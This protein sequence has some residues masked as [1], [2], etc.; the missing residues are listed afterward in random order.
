MATLT[1][2]VTIDAP[3]EKVFD[4]ALDI[5]KLWVWPDIALADVR[6]TPDGVGSSARIWT[7]FLGFHMEGGLEY[8]EVLRPERIKAEVGFAM[9]HPTWTFTFE[10][11]E[12]GTKLTAQGEWHVRVPAVGKTFE[13]LMVK[14]HEEYLEQLL[15]KVKEQVEAETHALV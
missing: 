6:L 5:R 11:A 4:Y 1:R 13:R 14:E 8:T 12:K 3:V 9:E 2:S 10:P 7:H 15:A